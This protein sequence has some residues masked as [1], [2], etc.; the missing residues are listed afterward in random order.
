MK[1][2]MNQ[3][4]KKSRKYFKRYIATILPCNIFHE[5]EK[6][7]LTHACWKIILHVFV[8]FDDMLK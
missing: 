8:K 6:S 2:L 4:H 5:A 7:I 1:N 3:E